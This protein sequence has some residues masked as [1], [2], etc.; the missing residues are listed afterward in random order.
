MVS[1]SSFQ[2]LRYVISSVSDELVVGWVRYLMSWLSDGFGISVLD[3]YQNVLE[4]DRFG[5]IVK[6]CQ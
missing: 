5:I 6:C 1:D 4:S 3:R 2:Y